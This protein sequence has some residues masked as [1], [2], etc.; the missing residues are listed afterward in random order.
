MIPSKLTAEQFIAWRRKMGM[1]QDAVAQR[2]GL[3]TSSISAY[4]NGVRK[5]GAVKIPKLV[6]LGMSAILANLQ[7]YNGEEI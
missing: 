3:S 4:E 6:T 1:S 7:P 2:L 5:E